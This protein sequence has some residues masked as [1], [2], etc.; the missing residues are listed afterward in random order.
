MTKLDLNNNTPLKLLVLNICL[1]FC[2]LSLWS[3]SSKDYIRLIDSAD[4]YVSEFPE[5]SKRFLDSIPEPIET[6]I[7]GHLAEY[8]QLLAILNAKNKEQVII[9]HN[10]LLALRY[11][12]LENNYDVA[13]DA[14]LELF[15]N[16]Y[17]VKH[18][19]TAYTYLDEA[20][21]YYSLSNNK[22]GL[23]EVIQMPAFVEY[24]KNNYE[25]SNQL[26]LSQ[27][28]YYKS[29]T[30]DAYYYLY[31]LFLISSNYLHLQNLDK[32]HA[33]F[34][35]LN[36]LKYN[37][38]IDKTLHDLHLVTLYNCFAHVHLSNKAIDSTQ[39]YLEKAR[40][41][42]KSMN[43]SDVKEHFETYI[44][45]Y[46][47]VNNN[48]AKKAYVDSLRIFEVN[49]L[50]KTVDAGFQM[51]KALVHTEHKLHQEKQK[52]QFNRYLVGVISTLLLALLV[53]IA[54]RYKVIRKRII[55]FTKQDEEFNFLKNNHEKLKVKAHGL[56]DYLDEVKKEMKQISVMEEGKDQ[57]SKTKELYRNIHHNSSTL[58]AKG[59]NHFE[60]VSE[61]NIDFFNKI[62]AKHKELSDSEI[63][64]C[65]YVYTGF[66]NKEIA[67][68]LNTT[69]RA[70]ESKRFRIRKKI[71]LQSK[72]I[73]LSDHFQ[74]ILQK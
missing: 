49:L 67:A 27:L 41:L 16:T 46:D 58:L 6:S 64:I 36:A 11:A 9:F 28:D 24:S 61:L 53:F 23:A 35:E 47:A 15:Y 7:H 21:K 13:G 2:S 18:D 5:I 12:K 29:I 54:M 14:N 30:D 34:N 74:Q 32:A 10:Y 72:D 50:E 25:K 17:I 45:Y 22:N 68:F 31:A 43:E 48:E 55:N 62:S 70:I 33:Y 52:N 40:N 37:E 69:H 1:L 8:Y 26:V 60:L 20:K 56:A 39:I 65:Y 4:Y 57:Q 71:N 38:T 19:S 73:S 66:K 51:N 44:D 63:I 3:Q 59:E 42:K